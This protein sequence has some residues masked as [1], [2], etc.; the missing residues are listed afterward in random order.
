MTNELRAK[1]AAAEKANDE[2]DAANS[3]PQIADQ[4]EK[5]ATDSDTNNN[6]ESSLQKD[7]L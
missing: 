1:R 2:M 4:P 5:N 7:E 3:A 6:D